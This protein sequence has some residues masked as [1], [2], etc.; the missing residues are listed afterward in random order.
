MKFVLIKNVCLK[1]EYRFTGLDV[2]NAKTLPHIKCNIAFG[3]HAT[4]LN[5]TTYHWNKR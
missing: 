1:N 4:N 3:P 5:R 2:S